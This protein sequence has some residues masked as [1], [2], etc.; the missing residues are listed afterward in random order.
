[1]WH[2]SNVLAGRLLDSHQLLTRFTFTSR[3]NEIIELMTPVVGGTIQVDRT[4][5]QRRRCSFTAI[6]IDDAIDNRFGDLVP[7]TSDD[8]L[9]PFGSTVKIERGIVG[10]ENEMIPLGTFRLTSAKVDD[11]ADGLAVAC[12]ATDLSVAVSRYKL[13]YA[14]APVAGTNY[15]TAIRTLLNSRAPAGV[16][17]TFNSVDT[18][19]TTPKGMVFDVGDDPWDAAS[20]MAASIGYEVYFDREGIINITPVPDLTSMENLTPDWEFVEGENCTMISLSN[21]LNSDPGYNGVVVSS[22][23][24]DTAP[25]RAAFWDANPESA[26]YYLGPYGTVPYFEQLEGITTTK[27]AQDAAKGLFSKIAGVTSQLNLTTIP[28]PLLDPNDVI[29]VTRGRSK[30]DD[31][32]LVDA[33]DI[34]LGAGDS[35]SITCRG[36]VI[37]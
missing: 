25:I 5:A 20:K 6:A 21:D 2:V 7:A 8:F 9:A 30:I 12:E 23:T 37:K 10:H 18:T 29:Q 26:T 31:T 17:W 33:L 14:Y 13:V 24:S 34:P 4:A 16:I 15:V 1:M 35:Q 27:Q 11:T 36:K 22:D 19:Y 32:Y 28:N 3:S